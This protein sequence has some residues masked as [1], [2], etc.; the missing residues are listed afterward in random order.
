MRCERR[1]RAADGAVF[2]QDDAWFNFRFCLLWTI[3]TWTV[4]TYAVFHYGLLGFAIFEGLQVTWLWAFFHAR[5]P[6]G[7]RVFA[8][9]REPLVFA[10]VLTAGNWLPV[11]SVPIN[12]IY[13][14]AAVLAVEGIVC[15][16]FLFRML[17]SWRING[18]V[19]SLA[20]AQ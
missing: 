10:V 6:D 8:P 4:G 18:P 5:K 19:N 15:G 16:A 13:R 7:L 11:H 1:W 20:P 2:S 12:S 14:L 9:L 3:T 17:L